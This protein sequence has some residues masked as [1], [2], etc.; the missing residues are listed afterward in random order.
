MP[1]MMVD[2]SVGVAQQT[3]NKSLIARADISTFVDD[4]H[5][6]YKQKFRYLN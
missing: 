3:V 6:L 2:T 5:D 4:Q 1:L